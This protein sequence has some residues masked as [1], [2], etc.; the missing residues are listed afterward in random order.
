MP[1]HVLVDSCDQS[2]HVAKDTAA[3]A[4]L[5]KVTKESL[6]DVPR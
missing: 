4:V 3:E 5:G 1:V 2:L 6:H